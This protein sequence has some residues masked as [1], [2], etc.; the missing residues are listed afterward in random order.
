MKFSRVF[1]FCYTLTHADALRYLFLRSFSLRKWNQENVIYFCTLCLHTVNAPVASTENRAK[2]LMLALPTLVAVYGST[3]HCL[4]M[5]S[6]AGSRSK[7][8]GCDLWESLSVPLLQISQFKLYIATPT[9]RVHFATALM[10]ECARQQTSNMQWKMNHNLA[11]V[12]FPTEWELLH[13]QRCY[14]ALPV[15]HHAPHHPG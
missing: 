14:V 15:G 3:I 11:S 2:A 8:V 10:C 7:Q 9:R 12:A 13:R 6:L 4:L 5:M 1:F